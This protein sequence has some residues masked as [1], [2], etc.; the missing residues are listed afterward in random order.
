MSTNISNED[1]SKRVNN[2]IADWYKKSPEK[3]ERHLNYRISNFLANGKNNLANIWQQALDLAKLEAALN[4]VNT[5]QQRL[6]EQENKQR[7]EKLSTQMPESLIK[8]WMNKPGR[9]ENFIAD[10]RRNGLESE[11]QRLESYLK[12]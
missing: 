11:A 1:L 7:I 5:M 3:C 2:T 12:Q 10:Y 8:F 6:V 9:L 4:P